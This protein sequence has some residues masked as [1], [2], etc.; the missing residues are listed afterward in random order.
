M[1]SFYYLIVVVFLTL[2]T[3]FA[4][5]VAMH[6]L[7]N[8]NVNTSTN[9]LSFDIYSQRTGATTILVGVTSYYV[10]FNNAALSNPVLSNINPKYTAGS[11]TG[12]YNAMTVQ[13]TLGKIAV[14]ISFTG[15]VSGT[16]DVLSTTAPNGELMATVTLDI[17]NP[18]A[19]SALS[20]DVT[21]STMLASN[22]LFPVTNN[23]QGSYDAALPVE[24]STFTAS[25]IQNK[26]DL[27]WQTKTEVD[28]YGFDIE[29][30]IS[31]G[32]W[33]KIGFVQG[34]GNSNSPKQYNYTDKD[35]FADGSKFQYRLKQIDNDGK[36]E[37]SDVVEVEVVPTE[38]ELSQ[39]YPNP[40]NPATTIRFS[41]PK[42]T[43]MKLNLYN[44]LGELVETIAEGNYEAGN[45]KINFSASNLPSGVYVYR[46]ESS[47]FTQT[48]KMMLLK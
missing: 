3:S 23:Y 18:N 12:D 29:R 16:G 34:H 46:I 36:F 42:Q 35:L 47:E 37:Y 25:A 6:T 43:Q 28:N 15:D 41:L 9:K 11:P 10:N 27:K 5:R 8:F 20:W 22:P 1:K 30:R 40:F 4:Q 21:N 39:N 32:E 24:L 14:T 44:M 31:T 33:N 38:F 17:T 26:V 48:K 19:T 7:T 2:S 45:Y 13:I